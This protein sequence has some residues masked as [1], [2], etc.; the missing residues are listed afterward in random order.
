[1]NHDTTHCLYIKYKV[2][3]YYN[4]NNKVV[5]MHS[6]V[7]RLTCYNRLGWVGEG[8]VIFLSDNN[9]RVLAL[10]F[11]LKEIVVFQSIFCR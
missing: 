1:M 10:G 8:C 3:I 11:R 5:E 7:I 9:P 2:A 6:F 4:S